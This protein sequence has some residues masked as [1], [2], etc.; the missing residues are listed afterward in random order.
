MFLYFWYI[1]FVIPGFIKRYSYSQVQYIFKDIADT[2]PKGNISY[3]DCI[4]KSK[5]LMNG[6]KWWLFG[7]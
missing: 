7:L 6:H 2:D 1:L 3:L 5:E 4:T